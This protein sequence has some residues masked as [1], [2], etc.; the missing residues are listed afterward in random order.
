MCG[1]YPWAQG[2][3]VFWEFFGSA[4]LNT[5]MNMELEHT[6]MGVFE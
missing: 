4:S 5:Y 2:V 3:L 1:C 6:S